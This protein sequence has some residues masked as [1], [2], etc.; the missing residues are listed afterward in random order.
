MTELLTKAVKKVEAFTPEI[1]DEIAQYL[2][3]DI[4]AELRWDDSLKKSPDTLKQLADRALKN[5]KSGHTIEKGF[6]EL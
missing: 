4:D 3:N 5:F 6:D 1:Q 2:L